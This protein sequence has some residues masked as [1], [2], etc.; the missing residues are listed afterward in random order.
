MQGWNDRT[1]NA[2]ESIAVSLTA[3]TKAISTDGNSLRMMTLTES[4]AT[5]TTE[6]VTTTTEEVTT[7]TEE[8]TTTS[9]G[10]G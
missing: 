10:G 3:L 2:L 1:V 5:T 6:E 7:T 8:V 9:S 4:A